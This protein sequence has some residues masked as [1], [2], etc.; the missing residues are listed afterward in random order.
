[1]IL[2]KLFSRDASGEQGGDGGAIA[3]DKDGNFAAEMNCPGMYHAWM[4]EDGQMETKI[5][6]DEE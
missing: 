3:L 1:M 6:W 2:G 4:Y 5:Y